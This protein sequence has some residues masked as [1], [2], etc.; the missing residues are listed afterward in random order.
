MTVLQISRKVNEKYKTNTWEYVPVQKSY[1][2]TLSH[3]I[4]TESRGLPRIFQDVFEISNGL[5]QYFSLT[6]YIQNFIVF[7]I[8][9]QTIST[10]LNC[11]LMKSNLKHP[12]SSRFPYAKFKEL[13]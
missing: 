13:L 9:Y 10:I 7:F 8:T 1:T 3:T 2:I 11:T 5:M 6:N 12:S 4:M